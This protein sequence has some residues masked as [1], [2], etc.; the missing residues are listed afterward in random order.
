MTCVDL[1]NNIDNTFPVQSF[2]TF[3]PENCKTILG[4]TGSQ[5]TVLTQNIRSVRKNFNY[6]TIFLS[7]LKFQPDVIILTECW[8]DSDFTSVHLPDYQCFSSKKFR[9][10]NDGIIV[11][12]KMDLQVDI[13]EPPLIDAS[14][15]LIKVENSLNIIAIY[16]SPSN[17]NIT[18]FLESLEKL[19]SSADGTSCYITGDLNIDIKDGSP[20]KRSEDYLLMLSHYGFTTGHQLPTRGNNCLDHVMIKSKLKST[21]VVCDS[22]ITDHDTL[23]FSI[24]QVSR[25]TTAKACSRRV[26]YPDLIRDIEMIDWTKI[27][28]QNDVSAATNIFI[29]EIMHTLNK[30]TTFQKIPSSKT[31]IKPWLTEGL[32]KC[33]RRRDIMHRK[34]KNNPNDEQL[35]DNY[36]KYRNHCNNIIQKLKNEFERNTLIRNKNNTKKLWDSIKDICSIKSSRTANTDL[37]KTCP[38]P[39]DAANKT[40]SFFTSIGSELADK[41]LAKIKKTEG[42]IVKSTK[43]NLA[44][45]DS[46]FLGPTDENEIIKIIDNLKA[47]SAPGADNISNVLLKKN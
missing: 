14:C 36:K 27:Y 19:I 4:T 46:F 33:I 31:I 39:I 37:L 6:F 7:R 20:D 8:L 2:R 45:V 11:L 21:V 17:Y 40:N 44:P 38:N 22:D 26:N 29:E 10:Q 9:N 1:I 18:N 25:S 30:H 28:N 43:S 3:R 32:L 35:Q 34:A 42:D 41:I 15:L 24:Y 13:Q 5:L 16:R 47:A 23:L 12:T